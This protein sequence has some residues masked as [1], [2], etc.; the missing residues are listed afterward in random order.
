MTK[1]WLHE[2]QRFLQELEE[3]R[4]S[5]A[6]YTRER[7]LQELLNGF[8]FC[9]ELESDS[10]SEQDCDFYDIQYEYDYDPYDDY[11]LRVTPRP[12]MRFVENR[13]EFIVTDQH[14]VVNLITG[15][16]QPCPPTIRLV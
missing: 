2:K 6:D 5:V 1:K 16:V 14:T 7:R 11:V 13:Y 3:E 9:D 10:C 15:E 12:G 4:Q 8:D